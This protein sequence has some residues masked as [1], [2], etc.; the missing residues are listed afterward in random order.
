M[1]AAQAATAHNHFHRP[2]QLLSSTTTVFPAVHGSLHH[3]RRF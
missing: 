1:P 2:L 3:C